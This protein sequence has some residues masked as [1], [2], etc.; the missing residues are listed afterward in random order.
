MKILVGHFSSET[1]E[2]SRSLMTF[3]KFIFKFGEDAINHMHIRDIFENEGIEIIPSIVAIGHPH[4]LIKKDAFDFILQRFVSATKEN[5]G[6]IDGIFLF[7]HGASKVIDLEGA[8]AEHKIVEEIRKI[9]GEYMPIALVM[10]PHG[11]LSEKLVKNVQILRCYRHSPHIDIEET[12]RFVAKKFIEL[13]KERRDV[14]PV[15][16]R[17]PIIVGGE[18]SVS[19]VEPVKSI[20]KLCDEKEKSDKIV[21]CSFH[22]GYLRHDDDKLGCGVVVCPKNKKDT[23]YARKVALDIRNYV[24]S[25]RKDFKYYG[26]TEEADVAI[27]KILNRNDRILFMTDS[28]DNVGS[29]ADGFNTFILRQVIEKNSNRKRF[30][31][32]GIV[33]QESVLY[34]REKNIGE[35]VDFYLGKDYDSLSKKVHING[36]LIAK[37]LADERY[38]QKKDIGT[39]YT[40]RF[41]HYPIDVIVEFDAIQ[42][43]TPKQI[44]LSGL[45]MDDYDVVV[46][47]QGYISEAFNQISPYC[48]MSLT[49]G[50]TNQKTEN[51]VFKMIQRPMYPYDDFE[52]EE[53]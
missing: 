12:F 23:E 25:R 16:Y 24:F 47:K 21:S 53:V 31:F 11:N 48:V 7:L 5:I 41:N 27:E 10:D 14:H 38:K 30:L 52:L 15:Y 50:P 33:D 22:V 34:L 3:D 17:I 1:N 19:F 13:L 40:V 4:G 18:K 46:V 2:H 51:L 6:K 26:N 45:S 36:K 8:S 35:D 44:E 42:Y 28:G 43:L 29:G 32:A 20:N 9:V 39:V 37:G 49:D